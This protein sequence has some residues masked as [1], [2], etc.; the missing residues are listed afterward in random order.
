MSLGPPSPSV[1]TLTV[2]VCPCLTEWSPESD[3]FGG[4]AAAGD[5]R[6]GVEMG[7]AGDFSILT[8]MLDEPMAAMIRSGIN[9]SDEKKRYA[10]VE[11]WE[12]KYS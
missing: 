5:G 8:A 2:S 3:I 9:P 7:L 11:L 1:V 10:R 12:V 4:A 6:E